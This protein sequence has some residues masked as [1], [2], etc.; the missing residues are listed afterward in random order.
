MK[1]FLMRHGETALKSRGAYQGWIDEPLSE[2]GR[3]ALRNGD[4][5]GGTVCVS[6]ASPY[7]K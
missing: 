4:P 5:F 1:I 3:Q 6:P 7:A 2:E